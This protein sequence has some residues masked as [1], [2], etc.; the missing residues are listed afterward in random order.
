[1]TTTDDLLTR[2]EGRTLEYKR[3]L[4]SLRSVLKTWGI[5]Y[6]RMREDCEAGG[7][8]L[9]NWVEL[10]GVTRTVFLP[11][12]AVATR[13]DDGRSVGGN[14]GRN[15]GATVALGVPLNDRQRWFLDGLMAGTQVRAEDIARRFGKSIRT[16]ERDIAAMEQAG[17]IQF[18]GARK[19]GIYRVKEL[20][21]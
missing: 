4:S 19:N 8:P 20:E 11:H 15:V 13:G 3:D 5:G 10:G 18:V 7:Y 17:V 12:P 2:P 16:A 9:P 14:D 21:S 6:K 1:M